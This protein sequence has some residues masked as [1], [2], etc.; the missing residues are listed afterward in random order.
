MR[1]GTEQFLVRVMPGFGSESFTM[2]RTG[3]IGPIV[4]NYDVRL[5]T[6]TLNFGL[7][8]KFNRGVKTR[9]CRVSPGNP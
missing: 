5:R 4:D 1:S 7:A 6:H 3:I 9:H 8:Y 2:A